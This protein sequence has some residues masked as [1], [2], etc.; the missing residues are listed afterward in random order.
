LTRDEYTRWLQELVGNRKP[1]K[2]LTPE[3]AEAL[4]KRTV[5][6]AKQWEGSDTWAYGAFE[7]PYPANTNKCNLFVYDVL[8]S[9]SSC[10]PKVETPRWWAPNRPPLAGEWGDR[11]VSIPGFAIVEGDPRPGDVIAEKHDYTDASGHVGIVVEYDPK[12]GAGK[13]ASVNATTGKVVINDWGFR[14]QQHG[15]LVI[16]RPR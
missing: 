6:Q 1:E 10:P 8:C 9:A 3:E 11:G 4:A 15:K 2:Q 13:T 5:D 14:P 16:R 7:W 12:T